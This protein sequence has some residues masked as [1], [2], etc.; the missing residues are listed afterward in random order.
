MEKF[1][2]MNRSIRTAASKL[3]E[4]A[5]KIAAG[6]VPSATMADIFGEED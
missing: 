1:K 6:E 4:E 2:V 5:D 3:I